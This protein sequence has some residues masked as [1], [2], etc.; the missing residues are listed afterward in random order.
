MFGGF[1]LRANSLGHLEQI[2]SYAPGHEISFGNLDYVADIRGDLVF[3]GFATPTFALA[4][5]PERITRFE[6]RIPEPAGLSA[7]IEPST[8]EPKEVVSPAIFMKPDSSPDTG[9]EP[10]ES[11]SCELGQGVFF[12]PVLHGLFS[13]WPNLVFKRGSRLNVTPRQ[14]RGATSELRPARTRG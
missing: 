1:A 6:D 13:P 14:Y 10:S 3:Q 7:A 5:D 4:L 2:D 9:S 11:A 12:P 8:G